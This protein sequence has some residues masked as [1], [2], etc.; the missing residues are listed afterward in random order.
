MPNIDLS[1]FTFIGNK[2]LIETTVY[3]IMYYRGDDVYNTTVLA[4][5][6]LAYYILMCAC[7]HIYVS[8]VNENM[9]TGNP[10]RCINSKV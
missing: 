7:G 8:V 2:T 4:T 6:N 1:K 10:L 5:G 3:S 9:Y